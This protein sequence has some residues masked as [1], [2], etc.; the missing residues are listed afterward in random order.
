MRASMVPAPRVGLCVARRAGVSG[1][2]GRV[3]R[4]RTRPGHGLDL[5]VG[6][7]RLLHDGE[8]LRIGTGSDGQDGMLE[9]C[10]GAILTLAAC[11]AGVDTRASCAVS[12]HA[13]G[14][15]GVR[16][17]A[18]KPPSGG[19]CRGAGPGTR[20]GQS[21]GQAG[22][23]PESAPGAK[24]WQGGTLCACASPCQARRRRGSRRRGA[25]CRPVGPR[26]R[27][28]AER[29]DTCR[30][31]GGTFSTDGLRCPGVAGFRARHNGR[32]PRAE[33][34]RTLRWQRESCDGCHRADSE[35]RWGRDP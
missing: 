13:W 3:P 35:C 6:A 12:S 7:A 30:T 31:V 33:G 29:A 8:P 5:P 26:R 10:S 21:A 23:S 9:R 25:P 32:S 11:A 2:T 28:R 15:S 4:S 16:H 18:R 1:P 19:Q 14:P 24:H 17:K 20:S 22:H 27:L 34:Q